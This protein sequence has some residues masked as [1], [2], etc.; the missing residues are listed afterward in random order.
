MFET[1]FRNN[2]NKKNIKSYI[3]LKQVKPYRSYGPMPHIYRTTH[4]LR[5]S[6]P[7][8]K[9]AAPFYMRERKSKLC[10]NARNWVVE[11]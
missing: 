3:R 2:N 7:G 9:T 4:C 6:I 1:G 11:A 5:P 8:V 10:H